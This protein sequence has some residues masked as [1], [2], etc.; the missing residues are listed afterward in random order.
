[1]RVI[2]QEL[3]ELRSVIAAV[4]DPTG[5]LLEANAGF[6]HLLGTSPA[7]RIGANVALLFAQPG[8]AELLAVKASE[9]GLIHRGSLKVLDASGRTLELPGQVWRTAFGVCILAEYDID[10]L[11]AS[12]AKR[13][14]AAVVQREVRVVD[15]SL[16]DKISGTGNR[17]SLDQALATEIS[18][19]RRTGLPLTAFM[20][21][22]DSFDE[23]SVEKSHASGKKLIARFGYMLRLLTRPTDIAARFEGDE[24]VGLLPHTRLEQGAVVARRIGAAIA[25]EPSEP[26]LTASFGLTE[27]Q[28]GEDAGSFLRRLQA[29]YE[30]ARGT[31]GIVGL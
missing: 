24:F 13:D 18:R 26:P 12:A 15:T 3:Q 19:V 14:E 16:I 1:M 6:M 11:Q 8:L 17:E 5:V 30:R 9:G 20:T 29:T 27:L 10:S 25:N 31:G 23:L 28:T 2:A 4:L 21:A 7:R 22:I